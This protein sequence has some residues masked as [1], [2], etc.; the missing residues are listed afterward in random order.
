[1]PTFTQVEEQRS[2]AKD[3]VMWL[4][5]PYYNF[6]REIVT[7]NFFTSH[8]LAVDLLEKNLTFF[9][10]LRSNRIEVPH[11]LRNNKKR[12]VESSQFVYDHTNKIFRVIYT[13]EE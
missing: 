1:M 12:P 7:D 3:V 6:G 4:C 5:E 11:A 13:K 10:T 2:L 9:G 8:G